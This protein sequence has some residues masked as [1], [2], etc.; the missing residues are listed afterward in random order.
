MSGHPSLPADGPGPLTRE[1]VVDETSRASSHVAA[2]PTPPHHHHPLHH[3][4]DPLSHDAALPD[5]SSSRN[6]RKL[7]LDSSSKP[8][9]PPSGPI[10]RKP[11]SSTASPIA[12]RYS[13][14]SYLSSSRDS[15][16]SIPVQRFSRS[17]SVDSPTVYEF[18]KTTSIDAVAGL[19]ISTPPALT[20]H[21][22]PSQ[23]T[24]G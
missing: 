1:G 18:P 14:G 21:V 8:E 13:H 9:R 23:D 11:V 15:A 24:K 2:A 22:T 19:G 12:T 20:P 3:A 16:A 10:R 7:A 4:A 6:I 17:F 5:P